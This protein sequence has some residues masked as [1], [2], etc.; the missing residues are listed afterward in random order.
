MKYI[1]EIQLQ[2]F[3]S[4]IET[5]IQLEEGFNVITGPSDSGKTAIIRAIRWVLYNEPLG[6]EMI[7]TLLKQCQATLIFNDDTYITRFRSSTEN[8]YWID[9]QKLE[10]F[11]TK[12]PW[13]VDST[14][15]MGKANFGEPISLNVA[16]QLDPPFLL[17]ESSGQ[18]SRVLG[19]LANTEEIDY[20]VKDTN[21][22]LFRAR[23]LK[24][25][26]ELQIQKTES[27]LE[28]YTT[29]DKMFER[30]NWLHTYIQVGEMLGKE[31]DTMKNL[32][33]QYIEN[34]SDIIAMK[35]TENK[36]KDVD[37]LE[38]VL[39]VLEN[40][41]SQKIALGK[42]LLQLVAKH[43]QLKDIRWTLI[44]LAHLKTN[45]ELLEQLKRDNDKQVKLKTLLHDWLNLDSKI[46]QTRF[47]LE[48]TQNLSRLSEIQEE[49][50]EGFIRHHSLRIL[51]RSN[52]TAY[53][54]KASEVMVL[55]TLSNIK[56]LKEIL[57][58]LIELRNLKYGFN[59]VKQSLS[60]CNLNIDHISSE[61]ST[62]NVKIVI[63][64]KDF[65]EYLKSLSKCPTCMS[66]ITESKI[67]E[68]MKGV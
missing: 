15:E 24:N 31:K 16:F 41:Y 65:S 33:I 62:V 44:K 8:Y 28:Q 12:R 22:D 64:K 23:Q 3:Q 57:N 35:L 54:S 36:Y 47:I 48:K 56:E 29:L 25:T 6:S 63:T 39:K 4:H 37:L 20:A 18:A 10:G 14:H 17:S 68:I 60:E 45:F 49:L 40:N 59:S 66:D 26:L 19:R 30:C 1:K 2:G 53:I 43:Q 42:L 51:A 13:E 7:N 11:G 9:G 55:M 5:T 52:H 27:N 46:E 21:S 58:S 32:N 67:E 34:G 50:K 61:I 38:F